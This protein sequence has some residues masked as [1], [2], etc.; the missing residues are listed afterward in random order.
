MYNDMY[1]ETATVNKLACIPYAGSSAAMYGPFKRA[2]AGIPVHA[3]DIAGKGGRIAERQHQTFEEAAQDCARALL[4]IGDY[5]NTSVFGYSMGGL[6]AYEAAA[7][8]YRD[9]GMLPRNI[10]I[11]ACDPPHVGRG[12]EAYSKY[13]DAA[14]S[15]YLLKMGGIDEELLS[16]PDFAE[17]FLP[18]IRYDFALLESYRCSAGQ[19]LP[20]ALHILYSSDERNIS[21]WDRYSAVGCSYS[22][23][24][25]GHFFINM[26][27]DNVCG[28]L[29]RVML[30]G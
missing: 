8:I 9:Y 20:A 27:C 25:G 28:L 14:L 26:S 29:K 3:I 30:S 17:F 1:M 10:F 4:G 21:E 18:I 24:D 16:Y 22:Y 11:A 23:F 13:G 15:E 7:S 19:R 5:A 12:G 6:L 2:L